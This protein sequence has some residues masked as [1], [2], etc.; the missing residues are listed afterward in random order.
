MVRIGENPDKSHIE[1]AE[2][3]TIPFNRPDLLQHVPASQEISYRP[4]KEPQVPHRPSKMIYMSK[5]TKE[6]T[7]NDVLSEML[8]EVRKSKPLKPV[9]ITGANLNTNRRNI[10]PLMYYAYM[11]QLVKNINLYLVSISVLNER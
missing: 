3:H 4:L 6:L 10:A 1:C 7:G 11:N 9:N 2:Y 5:K 8:S